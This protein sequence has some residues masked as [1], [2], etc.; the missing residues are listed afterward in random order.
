M[1]IYDFMIH[2]Q[3]LLMSCKDSVSVENALYVDDR[4]NEA[5]AVGVPDD[6]LGELVTAFVTLKPGQRK[7]VTVASLMDVA[8]KQLVSVSGYTSETFQ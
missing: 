6:R 5:A 3:L 8:R 4:V 7:R 2:L 1:R